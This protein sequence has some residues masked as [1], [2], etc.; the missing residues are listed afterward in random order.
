MS[1]AHQMSLL[2]LVQVLLVETLALHSIYFLFFCRDVAEGEDLRVYRR[3]GSAER[4]LLMA[5]RTGLCTLDTAQREI[6][7]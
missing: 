4:D 5:I 2:L 6:C 7:R 3:E 1:L